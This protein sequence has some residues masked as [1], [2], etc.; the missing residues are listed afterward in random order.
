MKNLILVFMI[1]VFLVGCCPYNK[2]KGAAIKINNYEITKA[3]FEQEFKDSSFG[4]VDT[5]E[6]RKEFL[7]N[8]INRKLILQNAQANGLDKGKDF[9]KMIER[10]WEQSLLKLALDRKSKEIAGVSIVSDKE[11]E[12]AYKNLLKEGKTDKPYEQMSQQIKW[13]LT[14]VKESQMMNQWLMQLRK[15]ANIQVNKELILKDK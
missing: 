10:F 12:G 15:G 4:Q 14:K 1:P 6:S 3:E 9:L 11:I 2:P 8:L 13:G 7:D 5:L